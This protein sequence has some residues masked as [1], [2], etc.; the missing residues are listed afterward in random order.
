MH[1]VR[2]FPERGQG[3]DTGATSAAPAIW[4][5]GDTEVIMVPVLH[6]QAG[7]YQLRLLAFSTSG[8]LM[9]DQKIKPPMPGVGIFTDRRG[10]APVVIIADNYQNIVGYSFSPTQG[11]QETF[12]KHL[13]RDQLR[14]SSPALLRDGHSVIRKHGSTQAWVLFGGPSPANWTEVSVPLTGSTPKNNA[15]DS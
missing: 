10:G 14:M 6:R 15:S 8:G 3:Q 1:W 11:F 13:T 5:W 4:R 2:P 12:R 7:A 9:F